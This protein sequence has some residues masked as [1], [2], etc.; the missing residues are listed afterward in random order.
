MEK[1]YSSLLSCLGAYPSP[2]LLQVYSYWLGWLNI[3]PQAHD[4]RVLTMM[5]LKRC[6]GCRAELF[7]RFG[8][9]LDLIDLILFFPKNGVYSKDTGRNW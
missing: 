7:S 2:C 5:V 3:W 8:Y 9:N 1:G 6:T 4:P